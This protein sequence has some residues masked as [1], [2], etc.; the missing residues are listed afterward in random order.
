MTEPSPSICRIIHPTQQP[1]QI[2]SINNTATGKI[3]LSEEPR[4][5]IGRGR[6]VDCEGERWRED[7][8]PV[9]ELVLKFRHNG[10]EARW[11]ERRAGVFGI[12]ELV[13]AVEEATHAD[14]GEEIE[15][16]LLGCGGGFV[17]V[18]CSGEGNRG[19]YAGDA[20]DGTGGEFGDVVTEMLGWMRG[21]NERG[22]Y[23]SRM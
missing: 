5:R 6:R 22:K 12:E 19:F 17:S 15:G 18:V 4:R 16:G 13:D 10:G 1:H 7:F 20:G 9:F 3:S 21:W 23:L 11:I 14:A 2:R 8:S